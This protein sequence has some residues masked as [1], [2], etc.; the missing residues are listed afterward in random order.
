MSYADSAAQ[1]SAGSPSDLRRTPPGIG[2]TAVGSYLTYTLGHSSNSS[3][4]V[5]RRRLPNIYGEGG[6]TRPNTRGEYHFHTLRHTFASWWVMGGGDLYRLKEVLGH[7]SIEQTM[8]Y[9]HLRPEAQKD[10][11]DR[12]FG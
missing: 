5:V 4:G 10:D 11:M 2:W 9:A 12:I 7:A 1:G 3:Q 8:K 6:A